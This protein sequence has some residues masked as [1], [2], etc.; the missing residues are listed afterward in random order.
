[1]LAILGCKR[2]IHRLIDESVNGTACAYV[3]RARVVT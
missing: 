1:V 2:R 3:P